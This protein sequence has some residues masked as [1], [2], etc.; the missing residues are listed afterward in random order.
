MPGFEIE[1]ALRETVAVVLAGGRGRRL[2]DLTDHVS[3]PALQFGGKYRIIDFTLSNCVNSGIRRIGVM[4]QYNSHGLLEH[5]QR[6][7]TFLPGKLG[8][9]IHV[10][11][12]QQ[13]LDKSAWYEGTADAVFQNLGNLSEI[14][15]KNILVLAGDHIYKMHYG[16]FLEDHI[17]S[18]ADISVACLEVP[19]MSATGFGVAHVDEKDRITAFV[20]KPAD[21]PG[22]PGR[23][24][25]ALASMGIYLFKAGFLFEQLLRDASDAN[26]SHDFGH[27][28]LPYLVPRAR[29]FAHRFER[30]CIANPLRPESYWRDVG[31]V[32]AYFD[33]NIDLTSTTPALNL[34]DDDWP[35]FT[36]REEMPPAKF[37]H[38]HPGRRGHAVSSVVSAGCIISGAFVN[39]SVIFDKARIH[40][41]SDIDQAV[42]LPGVD[43]GQRVRLRRAII[44]AGCRIPD[45]M[46]IGE[47]PELDAARFHRTEN[48]VT[49]VSPEM[50]ARLDR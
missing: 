11:P 35:I 25:V 21:P 38:D 14:P 15:A 42:V 5:L 39:R 30:S 22:V 1:S 43:I 6:G 29:V 27:D 31:T 19:R 13:S 36:Y 47:D 3:K 20:E 46:V 10:W 16:R 12:A 45:G 4:T 49:L 2:H 24:D 33:A 17:R 37:V 44:A 50:I 8:E 18:D 32:D 23:P 48:G 26:S 40:S 9:F 41:Y 28:I 7:W 34:Y